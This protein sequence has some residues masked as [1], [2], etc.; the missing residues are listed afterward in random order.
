MVPCSGLAVDAFLEEV[1]DTGGHQNVGAVGTGGHHRPAQAGLP[2]SPDVA[3]RALIDSYS[4]GS[5]PPHHQLVLVVSQTLHRL[6]SGRIVRG[7]FRKVDV[8]GGEERARA[9][10]TGLTV[11]V[12]VVV[13]HRVEG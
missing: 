7:T 2:H 1:L 6:G 3:N 4:V 9:I 8:P 13:G 11:H 5:D 12:G 10:G